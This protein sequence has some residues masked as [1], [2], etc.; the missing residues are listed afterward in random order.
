MALGLHNSVQHDLRIRAAP[1]SGGDLELARQLAGDIAAEAAHLDSTI[2]EPEAGTG[3]TTL[4]SED[5]N[6]GTT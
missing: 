1:A 5:M 6:E 4:Q 3:N 2:G